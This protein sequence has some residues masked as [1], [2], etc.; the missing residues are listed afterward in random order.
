MAA[1]EFQT[2]K[3]EDTHLG[4]ATPT[5]WDYFCW[6]DLPATIQSDSGLAKS[7]SKVP[8]N[9]NMSLIKVDKEIKSQLWFHQ[10]KS[11]RTKR[12]SRNHLSLWEWHKAVFLLHLPAGLLF[13]SWKNL[14]ELEKEDSWKPSSDS[15]RVEVS[16]LPSTCLMQKL[17]KT[18]RN[19]LHFNTSI[20]WSSS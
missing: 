6:K 16:S 11:W 9:F 18:Q 15:I 7:L 13:L 14:K 3:H 1:N 20:M 4:S 17:Q 10:Q 8:Q 5:E 12:D 19:S 2:A